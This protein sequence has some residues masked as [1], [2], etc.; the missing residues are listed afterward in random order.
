MQWNSKSILILSVHEVQKLQIVY[1]WKPENMVKKASF[2]W[3]D[4][5]MCC[6]WEQCGMMVIFEHTVI[7]L[8]WNYAIAIKAYKLVSHEINLVYV[9]APEPTYSEWKRKFCFLVAEKLRYR[10]RVNCPVTVQPPPLEKWW[11]NKL[12][13]AAHVWL[14]S[15][16]L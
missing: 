5:W 7:F 10:F 14:P 2:I 15:G 1:S 9:N 4:F 11:E 12:L 8:S 6:W 3:D 16:E 13:T